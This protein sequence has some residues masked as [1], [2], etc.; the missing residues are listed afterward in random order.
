MFT[1]QHN[2]IK[3]GSN[4]I[5]KQTARLGSYIVAVDSYIV[6]ADVHR[7]ARDCNTVV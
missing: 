4:I 7:I 3:A 1:A 6:I 5:D 2:M